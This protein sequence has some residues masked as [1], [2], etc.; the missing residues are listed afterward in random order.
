M[1]IIYLFFIIV[2]FI[3]AR[4]LFRGFNYDYI[5]KNNTTIINGLFVITVFFSHF[6]SY[7]TLMNIYDELL[8][9]LMNSIGQLMVTSFLFYSGFGIFESIKTKKNYM[10]TF[11]KKR[12]VSTYMNFFIAILLF[13]LINLILNNSYDIKTILLSFTGYESIGNSNWYMLCIFYLYIITIICFCNNYKLDNKYR[14]MIVALFSIIYMMIMTRFKPDYYVNT[15]LC[16]PAGMTYSYYKEKID[17]FAAK[18]Y[19]KV[20][21]FIVFLL[22]GSYYLSRT[23]QSIY[24]YNFFAIVFILT[25][26]VISMKVKL[27][28]RVY[29]YFGSNVFFIYILQRIPMMIFNKMSNNYIY[30]FVSFGMTIILTYGVKFITV[31]LQKSLLK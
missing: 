28:S 2:F 13:I 23:L 11:F 22:F 29:Y 24:T 5:S 27:N 20:L 9:N 26:V 10:K 1:I 21:M 17:A 19:Y 3:G 18:N 16:Y 4:F 12:F 14:I 8:S 25:I 30:F 7:I 15:I 31:K 6:R